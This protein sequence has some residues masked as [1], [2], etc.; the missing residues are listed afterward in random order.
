MK[1]GTRRKNI[2]KTKKKRNTRN[3]KRKKEKDLSHLSWKSMKNLV[4]VKALEV[5]TP[6]Q[7]MIE[8]GKEAGE[9]L[10][11]RLRALVANQKIRKSKNIV[12][13]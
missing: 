2:K 7:I 4:E 5:E 9:N 13:N 8:R 1:G 10:Q 6:A 11:E 12:F 3:P